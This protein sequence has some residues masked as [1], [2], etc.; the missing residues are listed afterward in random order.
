MPRKGQGTQPTAK[1]DQARAIWGMTGGRLEPTLAEWDPKQ[2]EFCQAVLEILATG[3]TVVMRPGSGGRSFGI[4]IWEGDERHPPKWLY[5]AEEVDA[6][7]SS[8]LAHAREIK[9]QAA[10]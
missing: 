9:G 10:D 6:W 1:S 4:A 5:E 3:A 8:I 7:A 2:V